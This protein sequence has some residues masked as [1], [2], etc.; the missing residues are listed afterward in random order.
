[1]NTIARPWPILL[2]VRKLDH[3]GCERDLSK[4]ALGLDRS[5]F[6][7]HVG[8]FRAEGIRLPEL[9]DAGIP[10][11]QLPVTSFIS[12]SAIEGALVLRRYMRQ[13][14]IV[15]LHAHDVPTV[16][17]ATPLA[18]AFGA[19]AVVS[20]QVSYR[21]LIRP[22]EHKL[23]R[24]VDRFADRVVVNCEAMFRHMVEDEGLAPERA[25][26]CYNGVDTSVFHPAPADRP[27][28]LRDARLVIGT[29]ANLRPEKG[30]HLLLEAF[31]AAFQPG[32]KLFIVG[33]GPSLE[34]LQDLSHRLRIAEHCVFLA[35][36][37]QIAAEMR[38][39]DIFVLPSLS[40]AFSN[41]LLEAM[42]SGCAV[43]G[44][45]IGGTPELIKDGT[46]GLLFRTGDSNDLAAKLRRL[47]DDGDLRRQLRGAALSFA[48]DNFHLDRT[49]QRMSDLYAS[50]MGAKRDTAAING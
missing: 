6:E 21:T 22:V 37:P 8:C 17:F 26:L 40:E 9:R 39:I 29:I 34:E 31:A 36:K 1:V 48:R 7:P 18:S 42:A 14:R 20:S 16:L 44:S 33:S 25:Y 47:I 38:S 45:D 28:P 10:I 27:E 50:L 2:V 4:V 46:T 30:L 11:V 13:H 19:R 12:R 35:G 23:L 32:L 43:I 24:M 49:V 41:A 5:L 3:G 15:L